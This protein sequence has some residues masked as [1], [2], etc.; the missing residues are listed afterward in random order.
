M[1]YRLG[2]NGS[3]GTIDC[4]HL[5]YFALEEQGIPRPAFNPTW[6]EQKPRTYLRDLLKWGA[7]VSHPYNGDVLWQPGEG[8]VFAAI[9]QNGVLHINQ[10]RNAV[11]WLPA[12]A[13]IEKSKFRCFR[14][15]G[16]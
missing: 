7:K 10:A 13:L 8:P 9:W 5:V 3:D 2:G 6:Y 12:G 14:M 15:R 4:I 11:H 16:R 1:R